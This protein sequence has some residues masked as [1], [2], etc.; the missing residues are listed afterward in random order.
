MNESSVREVLL[1]QAFETAEPCSPNW[2][3]G[4]RS[5]ATRVALENGGAR[6]GGAAFIALRAHHAMQRLLPR[7]PTA[8]AWLAQQ[9]WRWRWVVWA[10]LV[11]FVLGLVAHGLDT[12]RRIN[13][14]APPVWAAVLW[15]LIVYGALLAAAITRMTRRAPGPPG[16]LLRLAERAMRAGRSLP[17]PEFPATGPAPGDSAAALRTFA[18]QWVRLNAPVSAIRAAVLLH[19]GAAALGLGLT[20]G[21]YARGLVF[22]YRAAWESTFLSA[23]AV[24]AVL[25]VL[26]AP[27]SL[28][29]GIA[30][31]DVAGFAALQVTGQVSGAVGAPAAPWIHLYA[32]TLLLAV[33]LPR[34]VLAGVGC[35]RTRWREAHV[36]LPIGEAYFQRL[37]L[38]QRGD[39]ARV[40]VLP[41]AREPA[42]HAVRGLRTLLTG[43][44]GDE[45]KSTVEPTV[46]FGAE[47]DPGAWPVLQASTSVLL[48]LFDLTATPEAQNQGRFVQQ[49]TARAPAGAAV[50]VLVDETAFRRRFGAGAHSD[51]TRL[52]QRREAW[53]GLAESLGLGAVFVDLEA[54]D[55]AAAQRALQAAITSPAKGSPS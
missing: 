32:W 33:V 12:S 22:D 44:L 53:Q 19:A 24:H 1:L 49:L 13:L 6:I 48:A 4:D 28:L 5:W 38:Q 51:H 47:D 8:A 30:L 17:R 10:V 36:D 41:Y 15:N 2:T 46:P 7:E 52:A 29:S 31:P 54:P 26:L 42:A 11:G 39:V 18:G 35:L 45:V 16:R 21:L 27:A 34:S 40:Q 25:W 23:D 20:A 50:V 14:L 3:D 9:A 55:L 43:V 37:L